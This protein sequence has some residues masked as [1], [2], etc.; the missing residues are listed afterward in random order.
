[1]SARRP[2]LL[3]LALR[4]GAGMWNTLPVVSLKLCSFKDFTFI[5]LSS[6][7]ELP[8]LWII[9]FQVAIILP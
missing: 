1:M 4:Y 7:T 8:A 9:H 6:A 2:C 5:D 3:P